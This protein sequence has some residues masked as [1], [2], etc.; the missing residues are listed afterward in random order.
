MILM[1]IESLAG[2]RKELKRLPISKVTFKIKTKLNFHMAQQYIRT[3]TYTICYT[4]T[5]Q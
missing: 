5:L 1:H 2:L 3:C 4:D